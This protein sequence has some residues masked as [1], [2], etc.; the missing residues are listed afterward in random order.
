M[1][2]P[3]FLDDWFPLEPEAHARQLESLLQRLGPAPRRVLDLG[4]GDGRLAVPLARAGHS[5]VAVDADAGALDR[6]MSKGAPPLVAHRADFTDAGFAPTGGPFDAVL[7]LG[8]TMMLVA[9]VAKAETTARN[10]RRLLGPGGFFALD[11]LCTDP[12]RD[13]AE[14]AWQNGVSE[15]GQWQLVWAPGDSV[16]AIRRGEEIDPEDWTV[17]EQDRR[18][19]LWSRGDLALLSRLAGF[20]APDHRPQEHLIVLTPRCGAPDPSRD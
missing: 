9:D 17:R 15:D 2:G 5:V 14:G 8:N 18:L 6:C 3:A 13:V 19:R 10:A 7:C 4:A 16:V 11:D 1:S 12:W 20:D